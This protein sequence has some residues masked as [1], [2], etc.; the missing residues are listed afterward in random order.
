MIGRPRE[1]VWIRV[2]IHRTLQMARRVPPQDEHNQSSTFKLEEHDSLS[3]HLDLS[4]GEDITIQII[5][6]LLYS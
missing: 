4:C 1:Y 2:L 3:F 5:R 6:V